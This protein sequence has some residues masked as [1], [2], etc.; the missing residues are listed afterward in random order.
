MSEER[1][2]PMFPLGTVLLPGS[3]LPLQ[4]FEPRY[5]QMLADLEEQ[6]NDR[7]GVVLIER[8]SEVGGGEVRTDV[9]TE[10]VIAG[11]RP[12]DGGRVAVLAVGGRRIA[13][14]R[15][16]DDDPYPRAVVTD[17]PDQGDPPSPHDIEPVTGRL[18]RLRGLLSELGA[19]LGNADVDL[20]S[21]LGVATWQIAAAVGA[22]PLD[23]QRLLRI[24]DPRAR[25]E[26]V[27]QI[28]IDATDLAE[29]RLAGG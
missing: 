6:Q 7:F 20:H 17:R 2:V 14:Q 25:L 12:L 28:V 1:T 5:L 21:D 24:D 9:G 8:G 4:V 11:A 13:V 22:G 15:W 29:A 26:A 18:R 16:L 10:A 19:A 3:V 27:D 23:L